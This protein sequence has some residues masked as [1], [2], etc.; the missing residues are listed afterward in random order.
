MAASTIAAKPSRAL[1]RLL[2]LLVAFAALV[3]RA[4]NPS[5][6]ITIDETLWI[7]RSANFVDAVFDGRLGDAWASGHPG[8]TTMWIGGLAQKT[9]PDNAPLRDRYARARIAMAVADVGLLVLVWWLAAALFGLFAGS[10][11]ALLLAF[12]PFLIANQR[13]LHLDGLLTA[14][15][16]ASL[17]ALMRGLHLNDRGWVRISGV[18]AGVAFLTKQPSA[19]LVPATLVLLWRDGGGIKARFLHWLWPA[20]AVFVA[21]WPVIWVWPWKPAALLI[22]SAGKGAADAGDA[23]FLGRQVRDPGPLFYPVAF[24][25]RATIVTLPAVIATGVWAVRRRATQPAA[26]DTLR[27]LALALGFVAMMTIGAKKGDR[28]GLP[29]YGLASLAAGIGIAHL[30]RGRTRAVGAAAVAALLAL[31]AA[32]GLALHPYEQESYNWAAGGPVT[33]KHVLTVGWG[34]GLDEAARALHRMPDLSGAT[35]ASTRLA[36]FDSFYEGRTIRIE[37]SSLMTPGGPRPDVVLFYFSSLQTGRYDEIWR[38][39]RDR[40]PLHEVRVAG[41]PLVRV[42]RLVPTSGG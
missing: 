10:A 36:P 40:E 21:A 42:Y 19:F 12:D 28:Y 24:I 35:V 14:A 15:M 20:V 18:L 11:G 29:G 17:L 13:V 8:V 6:A 30:L 9:L 38:A 2:I 33:A 3:P 7:D 37:E 5:E 26:R 32:P 41:I 27:L 16:A 23:F 34:D 22:S 4:A 1:R 31:H 39:Y 25:W